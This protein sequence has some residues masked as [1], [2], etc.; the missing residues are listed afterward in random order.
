MK[1]LGGIWLD[2]HD[3]ATLPDRV[4]RQIKELIQRGAL[5][6]CQ[7]LPSSG[8][9]TLRLR[10]SRNTVVYVYGRLIGEGYAE[11]RSRRSIIPFQTCRASS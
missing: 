4:V 10:I 7:M 6:T 9:L 1:T 11:S 2:R 3:S 5:R 8:E